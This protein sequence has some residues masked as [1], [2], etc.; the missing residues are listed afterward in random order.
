MNHIKNQE[1][2]KARTQEIKITHFTQ[3]NNSIKP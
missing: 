1:L 3:T 2:G